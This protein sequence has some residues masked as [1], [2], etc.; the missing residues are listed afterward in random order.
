[1][2]RRSDLEFLQ[3]SQGTDA[4]DRL[5]KVA[6]AEVRRISY[7]EAIDI[8]QEAIKS[9]KKKFENNVSHVR[10]T[11]HLIF[12]PSRYTPQLQTCPGEQVASISLLLFLFI[13]IAESSM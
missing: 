5:Q 1:M 3:K 7:T 9:K 13:M 12:H 4:L 6:D 2:S 11:I 10:L 8:L